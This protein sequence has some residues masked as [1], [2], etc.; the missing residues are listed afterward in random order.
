[1]KKIRIPIL[2]LTAFLALSIPVS[3]HADTSD[4]ANHLYFKDETYNV[5]M[6]KMIMFPTIVTNGTTMIK[7]KAMKQFWN[8]IPHYLAAMIK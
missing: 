2:M 5:Y 1:M 4:F 6:T 3:A 8:L 7:V